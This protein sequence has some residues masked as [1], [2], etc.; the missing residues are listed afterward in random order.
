MD[1][2]EKKL[3]FFRSAAAF[4]KWLEKNGSKETYLWL[5]FNTVASKKGGIG[6]DEA[7]E[8]ALCFGWIDGIRKSLDASSYTTRFTPR[9]PRSIWS[10]INVARVERLIG[11][12]RM[13]PEGMAEF[14]KRTDERSGV[15]S[16]ERETASFPPAFAKAF[17]KTKHA[18]EYFGA[19]P[20]GYRRA[21]TWWVISAKK[22][23]TRERRMA[24]LIEV[25]ASR[26]W[27]KHLTPLKRRAAAT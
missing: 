5:G 22:A 27:I 9:K 11:A 23:E 10:N 4:R 3:R 2:D 21:A 6:Y 25:S 26:R 12:G 13:A 17:R 8:E 18:W 7:V 20:H 14:E 24:E 15:Y 16:F 1:V 19:Q